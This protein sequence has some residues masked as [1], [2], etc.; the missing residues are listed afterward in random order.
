MAHKAGWG[1]VLKLLAV[2]RDTEIRKWLAK[3][4]LDE[5]E[6]L[7]GR[8]QAYDFLYREF[9]DLKERESED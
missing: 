6:G 7:R 2:K 8:A 4:R 3:G 5:S 1:E 9:S